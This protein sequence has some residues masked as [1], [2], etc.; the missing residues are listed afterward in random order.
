MTGSFGAEYVLNGSYLPDLVVVADPRQM[1]NVI[2][3]C[4]LK[5]VPTM[6]AFVRS[7]P[8]GRSKL[9]RRAVAGIVDTDV[10]PRIVTFPIM[11]N[12][13]SNRSLE[14]IFGALGRAGEEGIVA[15]GGLQPGNNL[16][17]PAGGFQ[18]KIDNKRDPDVIAYS[19]EQDP[20]WKSMRKIRDAADRGGDRP[21]AQRR[22]ATGNAGGP[23][24]N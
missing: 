16:R 2:Q 7:S 5:N 23:R 10:D 20:L 21:D 19:D 4:N 8:V 18:A 15:R 24:R 6:G 17:V 1:I 11:A 13:E 14:L 22:R 9:T 12:C 3:E